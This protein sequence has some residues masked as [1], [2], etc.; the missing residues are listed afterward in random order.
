MEAIFFLLFVCGTVAQGNGSDPGGGGGPGG[1]AN[2]ISIEFAS[3]G[4]TGWISIL[5]YVVVVIIA[6]G[7]LVQCYIQCCMPS[8]IG[9]DTQS[10][11][12]SSTNLLQPQFLA[13]DSD[14]SSLQ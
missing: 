2:S 4:G 1:N 14:T 10:S 8:S 3:G 7:T 9:D 5:I 11:E 13:S 6:L 12:E